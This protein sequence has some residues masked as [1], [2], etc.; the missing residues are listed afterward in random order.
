M[1]IWLTAL[2]TGSKRRKG[3]AHAALIK[4]YDAYLQLLRANNDFLDLPAISCA[5]AQ[6]RT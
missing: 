3:A 1:G 6:S 5:T 2:F 4:R